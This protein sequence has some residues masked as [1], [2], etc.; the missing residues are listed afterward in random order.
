MV[1]YVRGGAAG[2]C[3][4]AAA[5][6]G[7]KLELVERIEVAPVWAGCPVGFAML[8]HSNRQF[9]AYYSAERVMTLA[10]RELNTNAWT[11]V[12]LPS[13]L[14]WDSHNYVTLAADEAGYL[15]V[16]GTMHCV[17]LVYFRSEKPLDIRAMRPVHQMT[18]EREKRVTYPRFVKGPGNALLFTYRDGS[19]GNGAQIW[20]R[21]D[22]A[23]QTW[24]RLIDS[25]LFDGQ[26][27]MN[28]YPHGPVLGKDG[29]YHLS[30][31]W[32]DHPACETCHDISYI[33]SRDLVHW[34]NAFGKPVE[35]PVKLGADVVVDP[36]PI[37]GG[38]INPCQAVSFDKQGRV[39]VTYTKYDATGNLQLM[40]AR[41]EGAEWKRYQTSDWNYR[42]AFSG[43]G[44]IV[45]EVGVGPLEV[46]DGALVQGYSHAKLG[47]GRWR[48][49]EATL[50]PCG[51][52]KSSVQFPKEIGRVE[53]KA[54]GMSLRHAS[55]VAA[56]PASGVSE[57]G[58]VYRAC[59]ESLPAN[60]DRPQ[61]G[62]VP[63]PSKLRVYK[64]RVAGK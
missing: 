32:R 64:M 57:D 28:A 52:V 36:V 15:H 8:T 37:K 50:K 26:G 20:N 27:K 61:P 56:D 13:K 47:G 21:Y 42:W 40:N 31:V 25:P 4:W 14:G 7:Q 1:S 24:A 30:W 17:P 22:G 12:E 11:F 49:D 38:L 23:A 63:P 9:L 62:G 3:L 19:S 43:G 48:L 44:S 58:F 54:A 29:F 2:L 39:V 6:C 16:S 46:Q 53:N 10:Q 34:E 35:L 51:S 60:R 18:G 41:L 45:S 59:W 5:A 55:D 33:R